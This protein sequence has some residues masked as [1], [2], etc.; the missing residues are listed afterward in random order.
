VRRNRLKEL[1]LLEGR[2]RNQVLDLEIEATIS[3]L[4]FP[5]KKK[6]ATHSG[7]LQIEYSQKK[8]L[9]DPWDN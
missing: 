6:T 1:E 7:R 8:A 5:M 4:S 2:N 3:H 9:Q